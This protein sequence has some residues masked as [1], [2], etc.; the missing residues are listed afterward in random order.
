MNNK[1]KIKNQFGQSA[2][3][4]VN[5]EIHRH[6]GDLDTL[7]D[8]AA[9][10]GTES[11]LDAATGSGHTA[12]AISPLV[13][14]VTAMDL[15]PEM[16][17]SAEK[18]I[19]ENARSNVEFVEGDAERM[20][21]QEESFDIVTCR[22]APH[23]FSNIE[24]FVQEVYRVLK[25][26]G[27]FL[28][29]DNVAPEDDELDHFYNKVERMRDYSHFRAW[30]KTEW[31]RMLELNGF[32]IQELHRFD[33]RF[34][35]EDWCDRMHLSVAEKNNLNHLLTDAAEKIKQKFQIQSEN[36]RI[37]SF[38][39]EALLLSCVKCNREGI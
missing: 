14:K 4:Y 7:M 26:G 2:E 13:H 3:Y 19:K 1:Q 25:P 34:E 17:R 35:F 38:Q 20:P 10:K 37:K 11:V 36:D 15:T 33:K 6:G 39:G 32:D 30:K 23:H 16:L 18:F 9:T 5:S 21:F 8:M 27:R 29:D 22:I 24:D 31:L 28:L 12:N